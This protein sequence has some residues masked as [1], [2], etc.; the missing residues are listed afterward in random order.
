LWALA[1][2]LAILA[3]RADQIGAHRCLRGLTLPAGYLQVGLFALVLSVGLGTAALLTRSE[4]R[5][6][7]R[8]VMVAGI[9]VFGTLIVATIVLY[10]TAE[11]PEQ[12][13]ADACTGSSDD[14]IQ[15]ST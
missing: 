14:Y 4:R 15:G 8:R 13:R 9:A 2:C 3:Y 12:T 5:P 11:S 10:S 1:G 6:R 7:L